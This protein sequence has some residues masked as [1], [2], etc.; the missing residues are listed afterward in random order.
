MSAS[1]GLEFTRLLA[2]LKAAAELSHSTL[3][4]LSYKPI[5][6]DKSRMSIIFLF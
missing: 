1:G 2:F 5:A 6:Q 4:C 3:F